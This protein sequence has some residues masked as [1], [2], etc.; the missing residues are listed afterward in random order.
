MTALLAVLIAAITL[1][2]WVVKWEVEVDPN[3]ELRVLWGGEEELL[4]CK[5]GHAT[6]WLL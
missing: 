4:M 3:K 5:L 1:G 6:V 2:V